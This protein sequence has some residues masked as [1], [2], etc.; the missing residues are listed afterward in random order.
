MNEH[1]TPLPIF[2]FNRATR[3]L[4][5]EP[6][7]PAFVQDPYPAYQAIHGASP[8]F[9]WEE[10]GIWCFAGFDDV[11]RLLRDRRLGRER[12][13]GAP[14]DGY[15]GPRDHLKDFDAFASHSMLELEPPAHTRLRTLVNRAFVSRQVERLRPVIE[16]LANDLIDRIE[17]AGHAD[18]LPSFATPV[19]V[20]VIA[21]MLG[22][23]TSMNDRLLDWSHRMVAMHM[24]GRT[25]EVEIAAN[26]AAHEFSD[27][28]RTY[29]EE[30]RRNPG[31][32]ILSVLIAARDG[33]ERLSEAELIASV[34]QL[35]NAG[36][37]A[38]VHQIGNAVRAILAQGGDPR[39]FFATPELTVATVEECLRYD[40][41]LHMFRRYAYSETEVAPGVTVKTGEQVGLILGAA[42]R[43]PL[44]FASPDSFDP[45]RAG[46]KNVTFGGGIHFC[47]GA[48]LARLE[49]QVA[50]KVL[51]DR[52][53]GLRFAEAPRYRDTYH[54][55]GLESLKAEW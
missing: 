6:H 49:L 5:L 20:T 14:D 27:F 18:L 47:I 15:E 21:E 48:P 2:D 9:F 44:A 16:K 26:A 45:S 12:P 52:L 34:I 4:S 28:L 46:Q 37:E 32:D 42:N 54:F 43:D 11:S 23:P 33:E 19:P 1:A 8:V 29:V 3:R 7:Q 13:P 24:H 36:H 30:R 41:P 25:R 35:L 53:P 51:F 17:P 31:D 40:A 10:F 22:V 50:L 38:T 55:H 39:R